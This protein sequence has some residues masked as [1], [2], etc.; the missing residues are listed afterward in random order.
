MG[1]DV[2]NTG[3]YVEA[4]SVSVTNTSLTNATVDNFTGEFKFNAFSN[5]MLVGG[6][7]D[8]DGNPDTPKV[9]VQNVIGLNDHGDGVL[10]ISRS[11]N[12]WVDAVQLIGLAPNGTYGATIDRCTGHAGVLQNSYIEGTLG[13]VRMTSCTS[14]A[15]LVYNYISSPGGDGVFVRSTKKYLIAYN[16]IE[17]NQFNGVNVQTGSEG[18]SITRNIIQN[19][20]DCGV[21]V[22]ARLK[23]ITTVPNTWAF[24]GPFGGSGPTHDEPVAGQDVCIK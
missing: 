8:T 13:G 7:F 2:R 5:S 9:R 18:I 22:R 11:M 19:N 17:F 4:P 3:I 21:Q 20:E 14:G 10:A 15:D 6:L 16:T 24:N 12:I 23:A 1:L